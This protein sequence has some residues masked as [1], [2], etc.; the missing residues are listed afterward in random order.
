MAKKTFG[1]AMYANMIMLGAL[2]KATDIVS[3]DA[4][5]KAIQKNVSAKT[6]ETNT[7]AFRKGL[8]L[9]TPI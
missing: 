4:V 8:E 1:D 6:V 9:Q 5:E 3:P 2:V 7:K